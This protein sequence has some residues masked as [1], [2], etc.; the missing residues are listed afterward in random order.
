MRINASDVVLVSLEQLGYFGELISTLCRRTDG[1][2][3]DR[4]GL[5]SC[6]IFA[7]RVTNMFTNCSALHKTNQYPGRAPAPDWLK[8]EEDRYV[9]PIFRINVTG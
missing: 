9:I 6:V 8:V 7:F 3:T 2:V 5:C 4:F 1:L